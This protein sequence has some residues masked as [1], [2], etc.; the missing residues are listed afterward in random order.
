[1]KNHEIV[2]DKKSSILYSKSCHYY[3]QGYDVVTAKLIAHMAG[4][5]RIF[6]HQLLNNERNDEVLP[7]D[8]IVYFTMIDLGKNKRRNQSGYLRANKM[9][10]IR[11]SSVE[12]EVYAC[13]TTKGAKEI[14]VLLSEVSIWQISPLTH[15]RRRTRCLGGTRT[16][17]PSAKTF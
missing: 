15:H 9:P 3:M 8:G 14:H 12:T 1:M 7:D 13:T 4:F 2:N 5:D 6:S 16:I 11:L 17:L 10:L